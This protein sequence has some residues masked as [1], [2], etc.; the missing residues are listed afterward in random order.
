M[1]ISFSTIALIRFV[2]FTILALNMVL[3]VALFVS[4]FFVRY[5][6]SYLLFRGSKRVI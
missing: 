1:G 5:L 2:F 4:F 3:F 6:T